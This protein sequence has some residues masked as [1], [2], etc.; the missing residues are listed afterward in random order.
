MDSQEFERLALADPE[1]RS[2]LEG[3]AADAAPKV[4][5]ERA[6]K[7]FGPISAGAV[8]LGVMAYVLFRWAKNVLD[9]DQAVRETEVLERRAEVVAWLVERGIPDET[10][11]SIAMGVLEQM[12]DRSKHDTI[13]GKALALLTGGKGK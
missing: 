7:H 8:L 10:A 13:L 2:F 5:G 9:H 11:Q 3:A 6:P 1:L 12:A 4:A